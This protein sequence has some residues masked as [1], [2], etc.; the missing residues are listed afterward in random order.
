MDTT[1]QR[2]IAA[3]EPVVF[4]Y[5]YLLSAAHYAL[6]GAAPWRA[7]AERALLSH[8]GNVSNFLLRE[9]WSGHI[10]AADYLAPLQERP[11]DLPTWRTE[12]PAHASVRLDHL[13]L[14]RQEEPETWTPHKW[15]PRLDAEVREAWKSFYDAITDGEFRS[16]FVEQVELRRRELV[17]FHVRVELLY[18]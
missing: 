8:Y 11:W 14:L 18:L 16:K 5:T 7:H 9:E 3:I 1:R 2:R 13:A 12:W 15:I 17:P 4:E 10:V 6:F